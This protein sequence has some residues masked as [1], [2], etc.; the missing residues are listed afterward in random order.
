MPPVTFATLRPLVWFPP[1]LALL[2]FALLSIATASYY[3]EASPLSYTTPITLELLATRVG[4]VTFAEVREAW[5]LG[6]YDW[7]FVSTVVAWPLLLARRGRLAL[8]GTILPVVLLFPVNAIGL[9]SLAI[10]LTV[11]QGW[12]GETLA[13]GW[14]L[15]ELYGLWSAWGMGCG[16]HQFTRRDR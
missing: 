3:V 15:I 1:I 8:L 5:Q 6:F 11:S 16:I 14:P 13:E 12:D 9:L 2:S 4:T 10:E 7:A